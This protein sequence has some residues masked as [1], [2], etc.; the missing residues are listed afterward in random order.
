VKSRGLRQPADPAVLA[1]EIVE[2]LETALEQ[3]RGIEDELAEG[4]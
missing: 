2:S 4:K 1:R 3:F